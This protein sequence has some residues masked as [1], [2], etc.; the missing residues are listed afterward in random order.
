[1]TLNCAMAL[2]TP[3]TDGVVRD[4]KRK[5][6][7]SHATSMKGLSESEGGDPAEVASPRAPT[8]SFLG[9]AED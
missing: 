3:N 7:M 5:M 6:M 9:G 2:V 4:P 1:M 8:L